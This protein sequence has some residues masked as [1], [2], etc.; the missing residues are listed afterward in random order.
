[1]HRSKKVENLL[2]ERKK[3][4]DLF[5]IKRTIDSVRSVDNLIVSPLNYGAYRLKLQRPTSWPETVMFLCQEQDILE[6]MP[7]VKC[8]LE[9]DAEQIDL[10]CLQYGIQH[11]WPPTLSERDR[12]AIVQRFEWA[13]I[14]AAAMLPLFRKA[15]GERTGR[16]PYPDWEF[17]SMMIWF[18]V[19]AWRTV[20]KL[21]KQDGLLSLPLPARPDPK[22]PID[23][24]TN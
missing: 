21:R 15:D 9:P 1:L 2:F 22:W 13:R 23:P 5:A 3:G 4:G 17:E 8:G 19:E 11:E 6:R 12:D 16:M 10:L 18:L 7:I 24:E 14:L 20:E